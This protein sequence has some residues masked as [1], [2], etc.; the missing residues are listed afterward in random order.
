MYIYEIVYVCGL[1]NARHN[2]MEMMEKHN[3][4]FLSHKAM[5]Y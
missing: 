3:K 5:K 4:G 1:F 2:N